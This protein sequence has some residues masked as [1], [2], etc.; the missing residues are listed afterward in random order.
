MLP[1]ARFE[2]MLEAAQP[3]VQW[4]SHRGSQAGR[5]IVQ[6]K[7]VQEI[8]QGKIFQEKIVQ[9]KSNQRP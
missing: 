9:D 8:V 3:I 6:E 5:K 2:P 7:I 4:G 1:K